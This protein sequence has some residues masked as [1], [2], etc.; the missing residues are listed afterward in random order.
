MNKQ[1]GKL[2]MG[3]ALGILMVAAV[4]CQKQA[5][6]PTGKSVSKLQR[7]HFD[8]D[9]SAVKPE[10]RSVLR[11][12]ATWMKKH[13]DTR[14]IIQG[15]CD[16]RGSTEYNIALGSRRAQSAK[17]YLTSLGISSRRVMIKSFGEERPICRKSSESCWW[18]NRRA[19]FLKK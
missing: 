12:N 14:V 18:K 6:R 5:T 7:I 8:F 4:G 3:V 9:R 10:Y 2:M 15:H 11:G 17:K 13:V 1:W 16:E 19:E